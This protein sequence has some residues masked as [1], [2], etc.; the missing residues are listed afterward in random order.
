MPKITLEV[1][2]KN[3]ETVMHI[4]DNLKSGLIASVSVDKKKTQAK[5]MYSPPHNK[6]IKENT[7]VSGKYISPATFKKRLQEK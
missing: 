1:T 5:T 4:L 6:V 7:P 3:L 2:D